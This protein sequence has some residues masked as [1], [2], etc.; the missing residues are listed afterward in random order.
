MLA[1]TIAERTR[2]GWVTAHSSARM[3]P[4]EPP[5]HAGP[6][7]RCRGRRRARPRPRP[8]RGRSRTGTGCPTAG[9]PAPATTARSCP[10]TRRAR[11]SRRRTTGRCPAGGPARSARPTSPAVGCPGPAGPATWLSPV[12]ACSTRMALSRAALSVAPRL[13]GHP[14]RRAARRRS[15][16]PGRRGPRVRLEPASGPSSPRRRRAAP[17]RTS[18]TGHRGGGRSVPSRS[19]PLLV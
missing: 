4:I 1:R 2:A 7:S 13:V 16:A 10:G 5:T 18:V 14:H 19:V 11:C 3:P 12:R 6:A 8:G 9:R 17:P 15:R